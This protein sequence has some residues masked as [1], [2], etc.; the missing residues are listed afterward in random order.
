M[1]ILCLAIC[2]VNFAI[3]FKY[4]HN[5]F[6]SLLQISEETDVLFDNLNLTEELQ[7][8]I[9]FA[10]EISEVSFACISILNSSKKFLKNNTGVDFDLFSEFISQWNSHVVQNRASYFVSDNLLNSEST[11]I[12]LQFYAGFPIVYD[13]KLIGVFCLADFKNKNL[14]D[15]Q[16]KVLNYV[17]SQIESFLGLQN[18][19]YQKE[20]QFGLFVE[21]SKEILYELD[22]EGKITFASKNWV[23]LLGYEAEEVL[24]TSNA[25]LIHPDDL[26]MCLEYLIHSVGDTKSEKDLV[27]RIRHKEGHYV[28]HASNLISSEKDGEVIFIGNCR[29]VTEHIQT[30][31]KLEK[32]KDFYEKILERIP[33]DLA[34][35]DENHKY[36]YLNPLAIKNDELRNFIIGKDDF[37]YANHT[38]RTY[39]FAEDRRGK[40]IKSLESKTLIQWEESMRHPNGTIS[41]YNRKFNPVFK[42]DGSFDMMVGFGVDITE[43]KRFQDEIIKNR[44]L[45][46]SIIQNVAVGILV[47]GPQSEILENNKAACEMLGL[48]EDQ[49]LGKTSFDEHWKVIHLDGTEFKSEDHPVPQA[50]QTLKPINN[51][52]MGVHRP[53]KNDLVWLLVDAIPVFDNDGSLL[54]VVCSFNDIT[55][56]KKAEDD[57]MISNERFS[58]S[59][60]ASFDAI[61]DWD[62]I[63]DK[64]F[65]GEGFTSLFGYQFEN[66]FMDAE[67][68]ENFVH[69]EDRNAT[70]ESFDEAIANQKGMWAYEYRYLKADGTYAHV[71]DKAIIIRDKKGQA[72][73]VIGAMKDITKEKELTNKLK[74]SEQIFKSAF[75]NSAA[76]MALVNVDGFYTEVNERLCEMFGYTPEEMKLFRFQDITY[77]KDLK[78]DLDFKDKLDSGEISHFSSEKR[79]VHKN[80]SLVWTHMSVSIEQNNKI[81]FY[82]VQLIDITERKK[83]ER[84]NQL[85]LTENNRNKAIQLKEAKNMY[86]FL[87]DNTA[88]LV[89]VHGLDTTFQYVS[90]S[91]TKL[92]GYTP[93]ELVGTSPLDYAFPEEIQ[94][95]MS[96][97]TDFID[98]KVDDSTTARFKTKSGEYIWLETKANLIRQRGVVVGFQTS[99]RDITERKKAE[100]VLEKA[101]N[102]E[103]E[104]NE[105]RTNLVSTISHEFRTPMTTIR[106]SA[107]LIGM[108]LENQK[109]EKAPL[110]QKRVSIITEEI[111]RIVD[112]MEA[113]LTISKEDSGKTNFNPELFDLKDLCCNLIEINYDNQNSKQKI[114]FDFDDERFMVYADVKLMEYSILNILNNAV[115]YSKGFGD[116]IFNIKKIDDNIQLEIRDFGIGIPEEEQSKLFNTFFR[117]SN[118]NGYQGTGLG[119][120]IVKTFTE[121]NSGTIKLEST[122]GEG[123]QV[124]FQFPVAN[125]D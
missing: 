122:L 54:Y 43:I 53:T 15:S 93:E 74:E 3:E 113:V 32:Q 78:I 87:A 52:V 59:N 101:L 96:S 90:P 35:F 33:T 1:F 125:Q 77:V 11:Q 79:F 67:V 123:T 38:G 55:A 60:K 104:L 64:I 14:S 116:I 89:C 108:Y 25:S 66:N 105:L 84:H 98:E 16:L 56:R 19:I 110:L 29:D 109:I 51:V 61:W 120:Y 92:I 48:T 70:F 42:E 76:G 46:N 83:I 28:W 10:L 97:L 40:F 112:L 72:I 118:T 86:R 121:K 5:L 124:T 49:L 39:E 75:K 6:M 114:V 88:D 47:Q 18:Q 106:T 37:E 95:L 44:Q 91:S 45:I 13:H 8:S 107:E 62:L 24:G 30:Q 58:F 23:D 21:N 115:K 119:L 57:L 17:L 22:K 71:N 63:S 31:Q 73:R 20:K 103:R 50:I 117:A 100:M 36:I 102:Q 80:G 7:K 34:V 68:C 4:H 111:D 85:L 81:P 12:S 65:V 82:I 41:V 2:E 26:E 27:F 99:S 9:L 69:P 94:Y